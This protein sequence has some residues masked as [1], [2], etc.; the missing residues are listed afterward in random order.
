MVQGLDVVEADLDLIDM[1]EQIA[2]LVAARATPGQGLLEAPL[3]V[4]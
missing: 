1:A 2:D 3:G 4:V